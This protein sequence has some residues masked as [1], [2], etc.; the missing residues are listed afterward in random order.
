MNLMGCPFIEISF[1]YRLISSFSYWLS[2]VV[3][4]CF[5]C[6]MCHFACF[7]CGPVTRYPILCFCLTHFKKLWLLLESKLAY[8]WKRYVILLSVLSNFL[9]LICH[10]CLFQILMLNHLACSLR[11]L[12][13]KSTTQSFQ[14]FLVMPDGIHQHGCIDQYNKSNVILFIH[15]GQRNHILEFNWET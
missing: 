5:C 14:Y 4:A 2:T 6:E 11:D 3:S 13:A 8:Y 15:I 7:A 9:F 10:L 1:L 12:W